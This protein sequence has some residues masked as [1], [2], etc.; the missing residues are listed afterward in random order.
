[1]YI[2]DATAITIWNIEGKFDSY[3]ENSY[4]RGNYII[5]GFRFSFDMGGEDQR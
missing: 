2:R 1:M 4:T 5:I 3:I